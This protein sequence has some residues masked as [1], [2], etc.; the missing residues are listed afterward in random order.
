MIAAQTRSA[1]RSD[2]AVYLAVSE[3]HKRQAF[4]TDCPRERGTHTRIAKK[5]E[6]LAEAARWG[7]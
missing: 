7:R 6:S 5:W 4:S 1:G 3:H 2:V